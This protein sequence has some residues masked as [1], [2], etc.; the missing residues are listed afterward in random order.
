MT[1]RHISNTL[2][3]WHK[4]VDRIKQ[5][6]AHLATQIE[7]QLTPVTY[8]NLVVF[9]A[10]QHAVC[11]EA[12]N[13]IAKVELLVKLN[14]SLG[15]VREALA[16]ANVEKGVSALLALQ[17]CKQ[18]EKQLYEG[19][20]RAAGSARLRFAD[21]IQILDS[22]PAGVAPHYRESHQFARVDEAQILAWQAQIE[23]LTRELVALADQLSDTNASRLAIELDEDVLSHLGM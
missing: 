21:A 18:Q 14:A 6:T 15:L 8:N 17:V 23:V 9:R 10:E 7:R 3:R 12:T 11:S 13:A 5:A 2:S 22:K 20:I 4:V 1:S 16:K 19:L